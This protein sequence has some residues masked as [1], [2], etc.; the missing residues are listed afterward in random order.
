MA[1]D[2]VSETLFAMK[3]T[4]FHSRK[5]KLE[6]AYN[7]FVQSRLPIFYLL[8]ETRRLNQKKKTKF[9]QLFLADVNILRTQC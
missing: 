9:F 1:G 3:F 6:V 5:L 8:T 4:E 2:S 7:T